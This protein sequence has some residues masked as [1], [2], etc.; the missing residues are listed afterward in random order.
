M[1]TLNKELHKQRSLD[2]KRLISQ[3]YSW[4]LISKKLEDIILGK[5]KYN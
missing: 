5:L 2:G 4:D 3:Y 1:I